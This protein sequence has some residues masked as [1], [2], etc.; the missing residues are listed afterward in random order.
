MSDVAVDTTEAS[1]LFSGLI[2]ALLAGM[3]LDEKSQPI[4]FERSLLLWIFPGADQPPPPVTPASRRWAPL[5]R[6]LGFSVMVLTGCWFLVDLA[7]GFAGFA[8]GLL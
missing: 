5:A 7:V 3:A 2:G 6:T 8:G 1:A 4:R